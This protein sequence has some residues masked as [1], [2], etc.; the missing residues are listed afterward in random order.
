[1]HIMLYYSIFFIIFLFIQFFF[2]KI[3]KINLNKPSI[4]LL[5]IFFSVL[6]GFNYFSYELLVILICVNITFITF[7]VFVPGIMNYGPGLE[8]I[9]LI[10]YKKI[11][12]KTLLKKKFLKS[13]INNAV[14]K[15]LK[16]NLSSGF[17][18]LNKK[19]LILTKSSKI[20]LY[21]FEII[22][23]FYKI[24]SDAY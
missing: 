23:K 24:K 11:H 17:I 3:L 7:A 6:I 15:R 9:D 16:I 8:I 12:H 14:E 20:M 4:I 5:L 10:I 21:I 19:K 13:R 22:K 1:M 2:L 18:R